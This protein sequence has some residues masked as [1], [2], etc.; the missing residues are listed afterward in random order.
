[1][2]EKHVI[3]DIMRSLK[4]LSER[5]VEQEELLEG[6]P[7]V[8]LAE[9]TQKLRNLELENQRIAAQNRELLDRISGQTRML[10]N[11]RKA[12]NGGGCNPLAEHATKVMGALMQADPQNELLQSR[13]D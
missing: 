11:I 3:D 7:I 6:D 9:A 2:S 1:M 5:I 8:R 10:Q 4:Q 12:L 13:P